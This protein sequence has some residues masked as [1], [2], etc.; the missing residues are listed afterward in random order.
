MSVSP[1]RLTFTL[2]AA[3][4]GRSVEEFMRWAF[5]NADEETLALRGQ[6]LLLNGEPYDQYDLPGTGLLSVALPG[7]EEDPVQNGWCVIWER[8]DLMV[9][10]KP[11]ELPVSRTTRNL[12]ETLI[13]HIRRHS[14]WRDARLLH[15]LDTETSGLILVA[16]HEAADKRWKKRF[17]R[18]LQSKEYVAR[19]HGVPAWREVEVTLSLSERNDSEIRTKMY[20]VDDYDDPAFKSI[21]ECHTR[22]SRLESSGGNA[23]IRCELFSG[24]KH[25]IRAHLS[26]IGCPIVG[27]KIYSHDGHYYLKRLGQPLDANDLAQLGAP[28]QQLVAARLELQLPEGEVVVS[29]PQM[30]LLRYLMLPSEYGS[31]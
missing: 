19:V 9:V 31:K 8:H 7:H 20:A 3:D 16:K 28:W 21:K 4:E 22:F 18:L 23:L 25:Q 17:D 6:T 2:F 14:P 15:R 30:L 12:F 10:A 11:P 26:A 5:P 29:L 27:D 24:R 1:Y 13:S